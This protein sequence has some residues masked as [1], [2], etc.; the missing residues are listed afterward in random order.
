MLYITA[1]IRNDI[2]DP[3]SR[4]SSALCK[5]LS[6]RVSNIYSM[7]EHVFVN[8]FFASTKYK[9]RH[10]WFARFNYIL[11]YGL[12]TFSSMYVIR[13]LVGFWT[14]WEIVVNFSLW[15]Y[16]I[17]I[18]VLILNLGLSSNCIHHTVQV[19]KYTVQWWSI[20]ETMEMKWKGL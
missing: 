19:Y 9:S 2:K 12:N 11:C 18:V 16:F 14:T 7:S 17:N 13:I 4:A 15:L 8:I 20:Q 5:L 1:L 10:Y 6:D 3:L